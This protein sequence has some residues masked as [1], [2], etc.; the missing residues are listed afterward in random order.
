MGVNLCDR[1]RNQ[2]RVYFHIR[3][4]KL[5]K[6]RLTSIVLFDFSV[7]ELTLAPVQSFISM[8]ISVGPILVSWLMRSLPNQYSPVTRPT[9]TKLEH[10]CKRSNCFHLSHSI[11]AMGNPCYYIF[12]N[13]LPG[14]SQWFFPS[15]KAM[16][17][18]PRRYSSQRRPKSTLPSS[19]FWMT[20]QPGQNSRPL[21][22]PHIQSKILNNQKDKTDSIVLTP[23]LGCL[24]T[25][26]LV[27]SCEGIRLDHVQLGFFSA[28]TVDVFT[29]L[30]WP[31]RKIIIT[32]CIKKKVRWN[33]SWNYLSNRRGP[34]SIISGNKEVFTG[35]HRNGTFS[36]AWL[37]AV[38]SLGLDCLFQLLDL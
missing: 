33:N 38:L 37:L 9:T 19:L 10:C 29:F 1:R 3:H 16:F 25:E 22:F 7:S 15:T 21:N 30:T 8:R 11:Q 20:S 17:P 27:W 36:G 5:R 28:S 4:C 26:D 34:A 6:Q 12:Q 18:K 13:L 35:H 14:I 31:K 24:V 32:V 2:F 23:I